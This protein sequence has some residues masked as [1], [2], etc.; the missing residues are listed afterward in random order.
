M[1]GSQR[2]QRFVTWRPDLTEDDA[3]EIALARTRPAPRRRTWPGLP[4]FPLLDL[5]L[6]EGGWFEAFVTAG[7]LLPDDERA[8][9]EQWVTV[10]RSVHEV[11]ARRPGPIADAA[12]PARATRSW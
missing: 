8:L 11:L 6:A 5:V 1:A 10:E 7:P 4:G 12:R 9:A 2:R 3:V